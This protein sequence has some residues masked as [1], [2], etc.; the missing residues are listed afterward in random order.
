M[1][2]HSVTVT[3]TTTTVSSSAIIL[4]IGFLKGVPGILKLLQLIIGI[5]IV[6]ILSHYST[7]WT[8]STRYDYRAD[9][10]YILVA[11]A[12]FVTTFLLIVSG[13][14]SLATASI[15]PKTVFEYIYHATAFLLYLIATIVYLT[16]LIKRNDR[17]HY[18]QYPGYEAKMAAAVL[19]FLNSGLYLF[20]AIMAYRF[21]RV[22]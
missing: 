10:F 19:G 16:A 3:R 22:G 5:I 7:S 17:Y 12:F 20:S 14:I 11:V 18:S 1:P 15:L 9:L 6:G 8:I 13:V 2:S 21:T 4:N